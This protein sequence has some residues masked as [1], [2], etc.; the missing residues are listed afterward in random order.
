M[1]LLSSYKN[2]K[3]TK[4]S[5]SWCPHGNFY[6]FSGMTWI[7]IVCTPLLGFPAGPVVKNTLANAGDAGSIPGLGRSPAVGQCN[8]L[9]CFCLGNGHGRPLQCSCLWAD[10]PGRLQSMRS[11]KSWTGLSDL[12]Q[13]NMS[14]Y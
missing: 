13:Q 4:V 12:Q 2:K 6:F 7:I 11:Q 8:P 10:E 3:L 14:F 1:T 9:Q 5:F